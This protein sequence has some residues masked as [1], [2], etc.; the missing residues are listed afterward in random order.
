[1][2]LRRLEDAVADDDPIHAVI[3]GTAAGND[4]SGRVGFT[5][6]GVDGQTATIEEA[7]AAA[8]LDPADAQFL[9]A[10]GTGTDLGDRIEVAAAAEAFRGPGGVRSGR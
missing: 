6:P 7:W 10:H 8:G 5:A 1:M 4:G 2:V 3:R 9:E